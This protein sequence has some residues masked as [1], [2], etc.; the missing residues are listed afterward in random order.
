MVGGL[1]LLRELLLRQQFLSL[2]LLDRVLL[3]LRQLCL[4]RL[5][6]GS[7]RSPFLR[8]HARNPRQV[9][10]HLARHCLE[11]MA[12]VV[13]L[14]LKNDCLLLGGGS[15]PRLVRKLLL[16]L[17][18]LGAS[19]A[20]HLGHQALGLVPDPLQLGIGVALDLLHVLDGLALDALDGIGL[21][22]LKLV[23]NPVQLCLLELVLLC[24]LLH[25]A[26]H[27]AARSL[28]V[29]DSLLVPLLR[30]S[31]SRRMPGLRSSELLRSIA[32]RLDQQLLRVQQHLLRHAHLCVSLVARC[33]QRN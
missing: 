24:H 7:C 32:L 20:A 13:D 33:H 21:L 5:Q 14:G 18:H 30:R 19:I 2:H 9:G 26:L 12:D 27:V 31:E 10:V 1:G 11:L 22:A 23:P 29:L 4:Q 17:E 16:R 25:F 8:V 6:L 28:R 3:L 15:T